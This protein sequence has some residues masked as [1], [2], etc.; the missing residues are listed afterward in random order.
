MKQQRAEQNRLNALA[1]LHK[2]FSTSCLAPLA[3]PARPSTSASKAN[4]SN[5]SLEI[6][7]VVRVRQDNVVAPPPPAT[8]RRNVFPKDKDTHH[9]RAT[10]SDLITAALRK[11][12][13]RPK[14]ESDEDSCFDLSTPDGEDS[15]APIPSAQPRPPRPPV[16]PPPDRA[17][18]RSTPPPDADSVDRGDID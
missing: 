6:T 4:H 7:P 16:N 14:S 13:P 1:I 8:K 11:Y 3:T 5:S 12:R 18:P 2:T 10:A 9:A 17:N 15:D